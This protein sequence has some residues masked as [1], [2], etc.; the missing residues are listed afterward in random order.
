MEVDHALPA[1]MHLYQLGD[2]TQCSSFHT[3]LSFAWEISGVVH[4]TR[5]C[6]W[7]PVNDPSGDEQHTACFSK[8]VSQQLRMTPSDPSHR[9]RALGEHA[10]VQLRKEFLY[11]EGPL[12]FLALSSCCLGGASCQ[13][14][15]WVGCARLLSGSLTFARVNSPQKVMGE[16]SQRV[17]P[18]VPPIGPGE[19]LGVQALITAATFPWFPSLFPF[20]FLLLLPFFKL[21]EGREKEACFDVGGGK[22]SV[23]FRLLANTTNSV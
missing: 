6:L 23:L 5:L 2:T 9:A 19:G 11:K 1:Q 17:I 8:P 12:G 14:S 18:G 13:R 22:K 7:H 21:G 10:P 3:C 20:L 4:Y 15:G 16:L